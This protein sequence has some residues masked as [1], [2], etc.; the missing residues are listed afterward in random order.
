MIVVVP[1]VPPW[2]VTV[3]A[4]WPC[5][6]NTGDPVTLTMLV[7]WLVTSTEAPLTPAGDASS[8]FTV[9]L[10]PMP[11]PGTPAKLRVICGR[12]TVA[13]KVTGGSV[14]TVAVADWLVATSP[15]VQMDWA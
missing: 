7:F 8:T 1:A 14:P 9:A 4:V 11:T 5:G 2:I 3:P 6:M 12:P 10:K 13:V 15:S